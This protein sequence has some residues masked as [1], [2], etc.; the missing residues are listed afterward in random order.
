LVLHS[1]FKAIALLREVAE[2]VATM[3]EA[4]E[5]NVMSC[6]V[7]KL[8]RY[9]TGREAEDSKGSIEGVSAESLKE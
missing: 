4:A 9:S 6:I 5:R 7:A 8:D 2:V 3:A 1:L